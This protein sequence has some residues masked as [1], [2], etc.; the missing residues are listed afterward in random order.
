MLDRVRR[1][2]GSRGLPESDGV[3]VRERPGVT[4]VQEF[5]EVFRIEHRHSRDLLPELAEAFG[6]V[7]KPPTGHDG[8]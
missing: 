5:T 1:T 3:R 6:Y 4:A 7:G 8:A 2:T